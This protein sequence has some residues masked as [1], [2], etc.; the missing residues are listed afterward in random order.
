MDLL[1]LAESDTETYFY[2][3][4]LLDSDNSLIDVPVLIRNFRD[5]S[6]LYTN[7]VD[8]SEDDWRLV[9]RF[10]IVDT[11][12]GKEGEDSYINGDLT[13]VIR[14]PL[15]IKLRLTLRQDED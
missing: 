1:I 12:S 11:V 14:W 8:N 10:Y 6:G 9:R 13:T 2:E 7:D 3:M 15:S 5:S 4:F